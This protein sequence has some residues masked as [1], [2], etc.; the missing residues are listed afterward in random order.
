M[1]QIN[2]RDYDSE[3]LHVIEEHL[4]SHNHVYPS[5][6]SAITLSASTAAWTYGAWVQIIP[7]LTITE[8]FDLHYISIESFSTVGSYQ[9]QLAEGTTAS[10]T[11]IC[12]LRAVADASRT[13]R[14]AIPIMTP[15]LDANKGVVGRVAFGATALAANSVE[16]SLFY[17]EY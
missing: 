7:A 1:L 4:H 6:S 12:E 2:G 10:N 5:L 8:E 14:Q 3:R 17:H 16:V 13:P 15:I 11:A 9:V